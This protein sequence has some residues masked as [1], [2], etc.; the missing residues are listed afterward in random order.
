MEKNVKH[1]L[2]FIFISI[3]IFFNPTINF[4]NGLELSFRLSYH[5]LSLDLLNKTDYE[6]LTAFKRG[7]G[8]IFLISTEEGELFK[9]KN[10]RLLSP[11][12]PSNGGGR[13]LPS[14][15]RDRPA[16]I[17]CSSIDLVEYVS[18]KNDSRKP[19]DFSHLYIKALINDPGKKVMS[20]ISTSI[21]KLIIKND[22]VSEVK[23]IPQ[24][25]VPKEVQQVFDEEIEKITMEE[26][27]DKYGR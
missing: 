24:N 26:Q 13:S 14:N 20:F 19:T 5:Y 7:P 23:E 10:W 22:R 25:S 27:S 4:A 21:H 6:W 3:A 11:N 15:K 12:T 18:Y 9:N 2:I 16:I 1:L 8:A 17:Y